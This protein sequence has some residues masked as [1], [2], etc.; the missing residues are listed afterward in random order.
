MKAALDAQQK[1]IEDKDKT[2]TQKAIEAA[3]EA[4]LE[5]ERL[6]AENQQVK[7]M[8]QAV[9]LA[10]RLNFVDPGHAVKLIDTGDP[11]LLEE[12]LTE[13]AE[14]SPYL[15]KQNS[16]QSQLTTPAQIAIDNFGGGATAIGSEPP[17]PKFTNADQ[18]KKWKDE[19][20]KLQKAGR[21]TQSIQLFNK[22]WE[23]ENL[24]KTGG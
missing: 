7:N 17:K 4:R 23:A 20:A 22:A 15:L 13:L 10:T 21:H 6:R 3:K 5:I 14:K 9:S 11:D 19:A 1:A 18:I 8:A 16:S 24:K 12:Q 2:E